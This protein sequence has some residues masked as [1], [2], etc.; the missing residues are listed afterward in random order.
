MEDKNMSRYKFLPCLAGLLLIAS[1]STFTVGPDRSATQALG[2]VAD[3]FQQ[4]LVDGYK[5][6][7]AN[8]YAEADYS[9]A[10]IYYRKALDAG[11]GKAV[12]LEDPANWPS[13][14]PNDLAQ[15]VAMPPEATAWIGHT[16][17]SNPTARADQ[18]LQ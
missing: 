10:D 11:A 3:P 5:T 4:A 6:L 17:H 18:P 7:G 14:A 12:P 1:C 9:S 8:Q 2:P 15:V 13:L 16:K